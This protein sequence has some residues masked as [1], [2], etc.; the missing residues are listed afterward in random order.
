MKR[1]FVWASLVLAA[2][3]IVGIVLQLYFIAAWVFGA[4]GALDAH[5][6]TGSVVHILEILSFLAALVGWWGTWRNVL[7][8]FAFAVLGTI[9]V[10]LA[11]NITN[12]SD[13]WLHGLHGGLALFVAALA[14][15]IVRRESAALGLGQ[16]RSQPA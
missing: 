4:S 1:P 2:A 14:V 5:K 10:F 12:P 3:V 16:D 8:S 9:Q 6:D 15:F 13:G 11:G 7:W